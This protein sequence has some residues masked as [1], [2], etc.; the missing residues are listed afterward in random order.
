MNSGK[1][2]LK[3]ILLIKKNKLM[4]SE[5]IIEI[6]TSQIYNASGDSKPVGTSTTIISST[7]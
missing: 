6:I 3:K 7:K 1:K 2:K 4:C 5:K